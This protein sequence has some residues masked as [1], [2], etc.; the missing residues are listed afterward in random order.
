MVAVLLFIMG[1][2]LAVETVGR[3]NQARSTIQN[4]TSPKPTELF[5]IFF[6]LASIPTCFF[7]NYLFV[8]SLVNTENISS[9][10]TT[11]FNPRK[12]TQSPTLTV[13][14]GGGG[15]WC[16]PSL[17]SLICFSIWKDFVFSEKAFDLLD[18]MRYILGA[19]AP[20]E[21]C[22]VAILAAILNFAQ[23]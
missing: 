14:Q 15:C 12:Y 5:K 3:K 16:S 18:N 9:N 2:I 6:T 21:A 19:V 7:K 17:K 11:T 13:V 10:L 20:L 23:N 4:T 8:T 22:D 1:T